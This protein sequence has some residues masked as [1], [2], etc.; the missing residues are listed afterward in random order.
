MDTDTRR[1]RQPLTAYILSL[2]DDM[3]PHQGDSPWRRLTMAQRGNW[4]S[5]A[6][7][8]ITLLV[9]MNTVFSPGSLPPSE[10]PVH[11]SLFVGTYSCIGPMVFFVRRLGLLEECLL[12]IAS[13]AARVE[14]RGGDTKTQEAISRIVRRGPR[15]RR[16]YVLFGVSTE[17]LVVF[18]LFRTPV[19]WASNLMSDS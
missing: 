10:V 14:Q 16:F 5:L 15:M 7:S 13:A 6:A 11:V 19:R 17:A 3:C 1:H 8:L 2:R 4:V 18:Y 9:E 12:L